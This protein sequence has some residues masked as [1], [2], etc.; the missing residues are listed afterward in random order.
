[1]AAGILP[2]PGS[3][4]GPCS[5]PCGHRDCASVRADAASP[6]VHCRKPIGYGVRFYRV[7]LGLAHARCEEAAIEREHTQ[8]KKEP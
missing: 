8:R 4:A 5:S 7:D 2:A 6:C 1:M 3:V